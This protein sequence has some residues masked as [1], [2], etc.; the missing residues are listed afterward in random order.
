MAISASCN[1]AFFSAI[2]HKLF[3]QLAFITNWPD[4]IWSPRLAGGPPLRWSCCTPA[5][6]ICHVNPLQ[7]TSP[8]LCLPL[9]SGW[10]GRWTRRLKHWVRALTA[11]K[12]FPHLHWLSDQL[13]CK[14]PRQLFSFPP[15]SLAETSSVEHVEYLVVQEP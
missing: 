4:L 8:V 12:P 6:A 5:A 15:C 1:Y 13:A 3:I 2:L 9:R 7:E 10:R 11:S 14:Y